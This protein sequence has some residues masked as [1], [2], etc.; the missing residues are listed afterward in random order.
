MPKSALS[1]LH[2]PTV[3]DRATQQGLA[4]LLYTKLKPAIGSVQIPKEALEELKGSY[5]WNAVHNANLYRRLGEISEALTQAGIPLIVLKGAALGSLLYED[6][7]L[8]PMGDIDLL[9]KER[10]L[11]AADQLLRKL[12]YA[13][14]SFQRSEAW[15]QTNHHHLAPYVSHDGFLIVELHHNVIR[16]TMSVCVPID[17]LWKRARPA[18]IGPSTI[19]IFAPEDLLLHT[20]LH[21]SHDDHFNGKLITLRDIAGIIDHYRMEFNWDRLL[22]KAATYRIQKYIYYSLWLARDI[23]EAEVPGSLMRDLASAIDGS[24][25]EDRAIKILIRR[26]VLKSVPR[27]VPTW[28]VEMMCKELL[29]DKSGGSKLGAVFRDSCRM[30]MHSSRQIV[31]EPRALALIYAVFAHPFYLLMRAGGKSSASRRRT[32]VRK[33]VQP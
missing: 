30:F 1:G 31:A 32:A 22:L 21:L 11:G 13:P 7:A 6:P 12:G 17:E 5:L 16:P 4:P 23:V 20:C 18:K 10:D 19:Q 25:F 33:A 3:L 9:L 15:Y 2:W 29:S 8:R 28:M 14:W 24:Y 26:F 27:P